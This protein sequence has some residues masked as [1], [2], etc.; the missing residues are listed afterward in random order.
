MQHVAILNKKLKVL[1]KILSG[2]KTIE[3]RWYVNRIA[4]WGRIKKGEIVY[5]KNAGEKVTAKARV[6]KVLQIDALN[7]T[8]TRKIYKEYGKKIAFSSNE[9]AFIE[10]AKKKNY[11]IL[12]FLEN[13]SA[14][15]PFDIDKTG[16][17]N[18]CAWMVIENITKIKR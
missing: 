8:K 11:C 18:A 2:E 4:P 12:V 5:F 16:F 7:T 9:N 14:V 6:A 1:P 3:S 10:W 17:G 13:V 15:K